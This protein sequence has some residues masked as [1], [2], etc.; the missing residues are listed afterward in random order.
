MRKFMLI[1]VGQVFS[2]LG[3]NISAFGVTVWAYQKTGSATA[4]ALI[5]FFLVTPMLIVSPLAGALVDRL[6]RKL[7]MMISDLASGLVSV[8][9][10][11]LYLTGR[12]EIWHFYVSSV[13]IGIG[14]AFQWP[15]YSAAIS[16]LVP[17]E[18]LG[19][20]N[21]LISLAETGTD[22]IAPILAAGMLGL[23]GLGGILM[24]D[25]ATLAL[26]IGSLLI[27]RIPQPQATQVG[28]ASRGSLWKES[29]YGFIYI[30]KRPGLLGLQTVFLLGNFFSAISYTL[31]APMILA[32]SANNELI[33]GTVNS[34]GAIGGVVGGVLMSAWGGARRKIHGVLMGWGFS[35]VFGVLMGV[36][37]TPLV[38]TAARFL[39][40]LIGPVVNASN[41]SIW[42][43]RVAP[44][45]QGR[46]F[47]TRRLIAW[48]S[49]PLATLVA[50]PL[51]DY[52][53]E[54]A[55]NEGGSLAS[56]FGPIVGVGPG[57][58]MALT[59]AVA[60]IATAM[61]GFGGYLFPIL[62]GVETRIPEDEIFLAGDIETASSD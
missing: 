61:I 25:L 27:V 9:L 37:Q 42:Q 2:L 47:S 36:G 54:P 23:L 18:Q 41:Q 55:M 4:L 29:A 7:M 34:I 8:V 21:G 53:M 59:I 57:A 40:T 45:V 33:L 50:G 13:L 6:N 20:A 39:G 58:G 12:L 31:M 35:G 16:T 60:S 10:L 44:D 56:V 11:A 5:T 22:I 19:R 38:W 43:A 32:R 15:A 52:V 17:K 46:V 62:R 26:A 30:L 49:M 14:Q 28:I 1:W 48:V 3:T 51:A 24:V